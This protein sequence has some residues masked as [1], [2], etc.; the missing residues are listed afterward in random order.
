MSA[1]S[2]F[3]HTRKRRALI[4]TFLDRH[5]FTLLL[6]LITV[7]IIA[8]VLGVELK[9]ESCIRQADSALQYVHAMNYAKN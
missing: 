4:R 1:L 2:F 9:T 6:I 5:G 8:G 7:G 3:T